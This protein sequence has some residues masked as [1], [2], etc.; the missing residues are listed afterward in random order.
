METLSFIVLI[1]LS[2]VG[3]SAGA[4]FKARKFVELKPQVIDLILVLVIWSCAIYSRLAF[5]LNKWLLILIWIII[6]Y[7]LGIL[8]VW[9]RR[10]LENKLLGTKEPEITSKKFVKKLLQTWKSFYKRMG[11]FQSRIMLSLFFFLFVSPF[12]LAVKM[13]SDPLNIKYRRSKSHWLPKK[14]IH[15]DL[16]QFKRQF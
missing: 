10:L 2:L 15:T 4:V 5:S 13:L 11:S 9:P 7:I 12:A 3:Y 14:D 16:E 1:L 6:G 8:V